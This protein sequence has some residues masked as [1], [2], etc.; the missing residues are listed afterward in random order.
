MNFE[1]HPLNQ[2]SK[3]IL[4]LI[5]KITNAADLDLDLQDPS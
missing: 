4:N 1:F 3:M 2:N 5:C